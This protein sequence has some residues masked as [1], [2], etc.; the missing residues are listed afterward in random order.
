MNVK[1]VNFYN[2]LDTQRTYR[3][4]HSQVINI[5]GIPVRYLPKINETQ[6]FSENSPF[7]TDFSLSVDIRSN[8]GLNSLYGEDV[9]VAYKHAI[10]MKAFLENYDSYE[11]THNI[12]DKFGFSMG[13][14]ITLSFEI[15]T[16]RN[17]LKKYG[18]NMDR[19]IESDIIAFDLHKAKNDKPQ[20]F[21]VKYCNEVYSY[22]QFGALYIFRLHCVVW[23]Y[24]Q[25]KLQT[26]DSEIDSL[27]DINPGKDICDNKIIENKAKEVVNW[28]PNDPF[29][30]PFEEDD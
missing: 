19:P 12:F 11:G 3:R 7:G 18:Y 13:D 20:L 2:H 10:P 16:W 27:Q 17:T 6:S 9:S 14:E 24:S 15:D 23:D 4:L 8:A 29:K 5:F 26:G 28:N 1:H 21:E 30:D 22:F 25:E